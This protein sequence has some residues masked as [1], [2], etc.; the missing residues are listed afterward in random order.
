MVTA[1]TA[2]VANPAIAE[3]SP[4]LNKARGSYCKVSQLHLSIVKHPLGACGYG[5]SKLLHHA[6]FCGMPVKVGADLSII[7]TAL[8]KRGLAYKVRRRALPEVP[9]NL[10]SGHPNDLA[11]CPGKS[12]FLVG[13]RCGACGMSKLWQLDGPPLASVAP[14][15]ERPAI[16]V[17]F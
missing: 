11:A 9:A 14:C 13:M 6:E 10:L 16:S 15:S 17:G 2:A 3:W 12:M 7:T 4:R 5:L 8:M 1:G